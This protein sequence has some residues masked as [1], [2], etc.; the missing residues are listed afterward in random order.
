M[1]ALASLLLG[2]AIGLAHAVA[3]LGVARL[4]HGRTAHQHTTIVL[5]GTAL[6]L[7]VATA[8]ILL[9]LLLAPVQ[10]AAFVG[11]LGATFLLGLVAEVIL[12][13]RRPSAP[14]TASASP[15]ASA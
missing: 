11:G 5:G 9:V 4:A 13:V 2:A 12:L 6:R 15:A 3:G 1:T 7:F 14:P 8:A 10:T